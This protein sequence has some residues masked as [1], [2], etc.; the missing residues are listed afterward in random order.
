MGLSQSHWVWIMGSLLCDLDKDKKCYAIDKN[1]RIWCTKETV[2]IR[3]Q[4]KRKN[5]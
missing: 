4:N 5:G 2:W 3:R 1:A